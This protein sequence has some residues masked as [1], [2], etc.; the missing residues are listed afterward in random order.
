MVNLYKEKQKQEEQ[1]ALIS[2]REGRFLSMMRYCVYFVLLTPIIF[3]QSFYFPHV[4]P[5]TLYF[6]LLVDILLILYVLLNVFSSKYR[7]KFNILTIGVSIFIGILILTSFTGASLENSFWG[8]FERG[9]GLLTYFHLFAFFIIISSV[10]KKHTDWEIFFT[11]SV[12][13]GILV[14]IFGLLNISLPINQGSTLG[15]SSFFGA[16]I[17]F[18]IFFA[19][20][21][22]LTKEG[23]WKWF[24]GT[25]LLIMVPALLISSA[26]GATLAFFAGIFLLALGYFI[27]FKRKWLKWFIL[28]TVSLSLIFGSIIFFTPSN[29]AKDKIKTKLESP[30]VQ[31]R[32]LVWQISWKAWQDKFFLGWGLENFNTGFDKYF[33]S[34]LYETNYGEERGRSFDRA[35]NI[36]LD[37]GTT[38]GLLGILSYLSVFGLAMFILFKNILKTPEKEK[39]IISGGLIVLLLIYFLQNLLVLDIINTYIILFL[40][41]AFICY[42]QNRKYEESNNEEITKKRLHPIIG[43]FSSILIVFIISFSIIQPTNAAFYLAKTESLPFYKAVPLFQKYLNHYETDVFPLLV[44]RFY[45]EINNPESDQNYFKNAFETIDKIAQKYLE[46]TYSSSNFYLA[47]GRFYN[48]F[49]DFEQDPK[50]LDFAEKYLEKAI[51]LNQTNQEIYWEFSNTKAAQGDH[52]EQLKYLQKAVDLNPRLGQSNWYLAMAYKAA[53]MEELSKKKIE[54]NKKIKFDWTEKMK[55][56]H[57]IINFYINYGDYNTAFFLMKDGLNPK[58]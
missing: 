9:M 55:E 21:L 37:T 58:F 6:R 15:N 26:I 29:F 42:L 53:G 16:Y 33:D 14:S 32:F 5:K 43:A 2:K 56:L 18:D 31:S 48:L 50:N 57:P 1:A 11:V 23:N 54:E 47:L 19:I 41:L 17:L 44:N 30:T 20:I 51:S 39:I 46:K 24:Y 10:F 40:I 22:F 12:L 36:I 8:N 13:T 4:S 45:E 27:F 25:S 28:L 35:H 34:K 52:K 7:P 3:S 38:S 49:F